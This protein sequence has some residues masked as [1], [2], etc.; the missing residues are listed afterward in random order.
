MPYSSCFAAAVTFTPT[1][2]TKFLGA[3]TTVTVTWIS[4]LLELP[5][6]QMAYVPYER[7]HVVYELFDTASTRLKPGV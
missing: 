3:E 2:L 4:K 7:A 5:R 6:R 1:A